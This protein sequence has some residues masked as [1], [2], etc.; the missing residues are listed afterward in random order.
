[1]KEKFISPKIA[2]TIEIPIPIAYISLSQK[3]VFNIATLLYI[4]TNIN[5]EPI[6]KVEIPDVEQRLITNKIIAKISQNGK[7]I[8]EFPIVLSNPSHTALRS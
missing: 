3:E 2:K 1:M 7:V 4:S 5:G 6:I 8:K